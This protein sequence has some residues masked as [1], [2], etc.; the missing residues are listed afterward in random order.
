[1]DI[2]VGNTGDVYSDDNYQGIFPD[3][4]FTCSGWL[5]SWVFG[6]EWEGNSQSFIELQVWRPV[7]G[8]GVYTKVGSTTVVTSENRS[9]L[10]YYNLSS[11][12]AFETGDILGY[13]QPPSDNSQISLIFEK[14]TKGNLQRGYYYHNLSISASYLD[15]RQGTL[16]NSYQVFINVITGKCYNVNISQNS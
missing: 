5:L 14:D 9:Q 15:I 16:Y 1:M 11:P 13:Y 12:L 10:Y 8:D 7:G 2:A 6:A 4:G 3:V